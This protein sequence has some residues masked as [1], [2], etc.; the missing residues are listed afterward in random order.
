LNRATLFWDVGPA[1]VDKGKGGKYLILPHDCKE[2]IPDSYIPLP[3]SNYEGY[4][5]LH[6]VLKS[7]SKG[8]RAKAIAYGKRIMLYPLLEA[9]D[10][11]PTIFVDAIEVAFDS[12]IP[13]DMRFF[14]RSAISTPSTEIDESFKNGT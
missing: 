1:G 9:A 8:D 14:M 2:A 13:Y 12:T 4:P 7:S 3:S 5:L 6:S 10:P 11:P